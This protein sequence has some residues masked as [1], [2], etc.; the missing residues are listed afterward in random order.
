MKTISA[1]LVWFSKQKLREKLLIGG[2]GLFF[3]IGM[4]GLLS[5]IFTRPEQKSPALTA[6][7]EGEGSIAFI[8]WTPAPTTTSSP[9][10]TVSAIPTGSPTLTPAPLPTGLP[11]RSF[12]TATVVVLPATLSAATAGVLVLITGVDKKLEYVD[13]QNAGNPPV[14]LSG[15]VLVSEAG[16]QSCKLKGILQPKEVL[17]IWAGTGQVGFSCGFKRTIWLDNQP[18]PAVLYNAKA[19]EVSRYP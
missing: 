12:D 16:N 6:T 18:D 7:N 2:V 14:N 3:L 5:L 10:P 15:W 1:L 4:C 19:E 9:S 13:I 11:T 17:R 8:T